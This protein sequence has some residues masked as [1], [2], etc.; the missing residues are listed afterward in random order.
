MKVA[1][2]VSRKRNKTY[3]LATP[4]SWTER[5][6]LENSA[7]WKPS[8][9]KY[10]HDG[11]ITF[12]K[13]ACNALFEDLNDVTPYEDEDNNHEEG[14]DMSQEEA[15]E[16]SVQELRKQAAEKAK[17]EGRPTTDLRTKW[18]RQQLEAYL[19]DGTWHDVNTPGMPQPGTAGADAFGQ[20]MAAMIMP[21]LNVT[22]DPEVLQ[23]LVLEEVKKAAKVIRIERDFGDEVKVKDIGKQHKQFERLLNWCRKLSKKNVYLWG[24]AGGGKTTAAK[25][26][27]EAL[28]LEFDAISIGPM[29]TKT[30]IFGFKAANGEAVYYNRFR[31]L[32]ENGGVMLF[33]EYDTGGAVVTMLNSALDNGFCSAF[34]DGTVQRSP[35]FIV[36]AC[37]NT[38]MLG[39][40][41]NYT[42]RQKTD[43]AA[44]ERFK[45]M[46]WE[47]DR[48]FEEALS[49]NERWTAHVQKL[50]AAAEKVKVNI[51]I[52]P[53]AS[54]EGSELL[55]MGELWDDVE[56]AVIWKGLPYEQVQKVKANM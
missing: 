1:T 21:W 32:Y 27:A 6:Y 38:P 52:S 10:G 34:P 13:K 56:E 48:D 20:M 29:T 55:E 22:P 12:D 24:G 47:Y 8:N 19:T 31:H 43:A 3:W 18:N 4:E 9:P 33:D 45:Y 37:G 51:V 26:V 41:T 5:S 44:R 11:F 53:R 2:K 40:D 42:A 23:E 25:A 28:D 39:A 50:R 54:I 17:A 49:S 16:L 14:E 7:A 30:D 35:K 36:I 15:K 46:K